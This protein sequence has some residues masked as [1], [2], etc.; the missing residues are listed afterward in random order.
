VERRLIPVSAVFSSERYVI[1][2]ITIAC[3]TRFMIEGFLSVA[4][5]HFLKI[6]NTGFE[7]GDEEE[8]RVGKQG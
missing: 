3:I 4:R 2:D 6:K 7:G 5:S 8:E 1:Y